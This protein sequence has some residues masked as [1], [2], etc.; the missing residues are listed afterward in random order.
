MLLTIEKCIAV[1]TNIAWGSSQVSFHF[2]HRC[3]WVWDWGSIL[4]GQLQGE[5]PVQFLSRQLLTH[6]EQ[7]Y[8]TIEEEV[9]AVI[10]AVETLLYYLWRVSFIIVTD[11]LGCI[12]WRTLIPD[13][14]GDIW[15]CRPY[16][17]VIRHQDHANTDFFL[18]SDGAEL[19][20]WESPRR[21]ECHT[22]KSEVRSFPMGPL[23]SPASDS[24]V[25]LPP[26]PWA[27]S[28]V[29]VGWKKQ[30]GT[31]EHQYL[32]NVLETVGACVPMM[33]NNP[34]WIPRPREG[35]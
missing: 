2:I 16:F 27:K 10:W 14:L 7:N 9:L 29:P 3:F 20:G 28:D 23:P 15:L 11:R 1:G 21:R 13:W 35:S 32:L 22:P 19:F 31:E 30:F 34:P 25:T 8:A 33:G 24:K 18:S 6:A 26:H 5:R 4:T 17:F 12:K